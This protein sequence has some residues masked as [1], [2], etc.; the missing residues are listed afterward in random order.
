MLDQ[1][2]QQR[3][4]AEETARFMDGGFRQLDLSA[5]PDINS[6]GRAARTTLGPPKTERSIFRTLRRL[7]GRQLV[8]VCTERQVF[9]LG[10]DDFRSV[11]NSNFSGAGTM[12]SPKPTSICR[13]MRTLPSR[14]SSSTRTS[15]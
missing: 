10:A 14:A 5:F 4:I 1:T 2:M 3:V 6:P 11:G 12:A 13:G 15:S 7:P 9:S 8:E